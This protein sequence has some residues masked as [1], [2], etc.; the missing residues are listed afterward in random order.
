[1]DKNATCPNLI[2]EYQD[3]GNN[4]R[5]YANLQ[6]AQLTV[7]VAMTG[8]LLALLFRTDR[9]VSTPARTVLKVAGAILPLLFEVMN[10]RVFKH[11]QTYWKRAKEIEA[12]LSYKQ[13]TNRPPTSLLSN[14]N[15]VRALYGLA[16]IFCIV[17]IVWPHHF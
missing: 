12:A 7:F 15:A 9:A 2:H 17:T 1:M 13:Y 5:H 16:L 3:I 8:G 11:W 6:F 4:L 14:A 10:E